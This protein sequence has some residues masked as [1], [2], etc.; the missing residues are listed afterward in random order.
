M[1]K[2]KVDFSDEN[3]REAYRHTS[4]HIMAQ[5][6]KRLW[7]E[8]KL[9]IGPAIKDGFYYD[10]D[11]DHKITDDDLKKIQ[12]EMKK[13]I[14]ANYPLEKSILPRD[15]ALELMRQKD[16][17]YKVELINDLPS[18]EEISFYTQGE[19]IDLCAGPHVE[20]TG[21]IKA[22]KLMS[23]AGAYWRG[24]EKNKMLQRVYGTAFPSQEELQEY[25]D[26]IEEAKKR[27]HRKI[28]KEM[29]LF[30]LMEE[31][32]GFP[33]F[34]PN[35]M[36]PRTEL[37]NYWRQEHRKRGY[38][39]IKTPLILSEELWHTSGHYDHYKENMYFTSI[40]DAEY[41]IKPMNCPGAMLT[42]KRKLYSYRD[43][44]IRL[45]ELGQVHRHELHGALH[46]LMRVRTFTQDDAHIFMT[47]DI[48]KDEIKRVVSFID[49]VYNLFGFKYHIELSTRPEDS[50]GTDEEWDHAIDSLEAAIKEMGKDYVIN[51]GDGAFY[52]PKL[53]FHLEDSL[54][55]TW[56]CGTIQLDFQMP[57]KFDLTYVGSDGEK[58]RPIIIHR[59]IFGSIER[60]I[61]ILIEH[62]AGKF[63]LWLAPEQVRL[64]T[65]TE[66]FV[67]YAEKV[68]EELAKHGIRVKVDARN[69]KI[70]YKLRQG[71]NERVSYLA[72]IGEREAEADTLSVRSSKEGDLGSLSIDKFIDALCDEI[73]TKKL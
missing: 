11:L 42:Y 17:D 58:H 41:A 66:K 3:V 60:F 14:K 35:G 27:D 12:K 9:A 57:Q 33:F 13:I 73:A 22:I 55:R 28:G 4:S 37:E 49:D 59:V 61:G 1:G 64:L 46:G 20:S 7:P 69:E 21:K 24:N 47:P 25:I 10:V 6:I 65:V 38:D 18:D 40:D 29:D 19:F 2:G 26:R 45:A 30:A 43:F 34:L 36:I 67:P 23:V 56:Q 44:P 52:G 62:F 51:E 8:A 15:K 53:D 63:P 70:G 50:M 72:V 39:E 71:R 5:A 68:S 32:P 48:V 54:G 16:E 31:G